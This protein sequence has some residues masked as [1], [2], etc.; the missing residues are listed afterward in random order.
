MTETNQVRGRGRLAGALLVLALVV[1]P[2]FAAAADVLETRARSAFLIDHSSRTVLYAKAPDEA[3][4]PGSLAKVMTAAVVFDALKSG[5][6]F[7]ETL[8]KVSE[9][10]WRTG[11]APSRTSTMFAAVRSE[12]PVADL[13]RGLL[14]HNANDAAIVLAEG[15][16][17]SETAFAQ[18]MTALATR[19]GMI[20]SRFANPTGFEDPGNRTT[21][22]DM[23]RLAA[24]ILDTHR[25]RYELFSLPEFTWNRIFQRNKNPLLGEIRGLDGLGAGL[26]Q[27]DGYSGL[28]SVE[29]DGRRVI[30]VIAGLDTDKMRLAALRDLVEGAWEAFQVQILFGRGEP[31]ASAR[32]YGGETG[33]VPLVAKD[34]IAVLLPVGGNRDYR[35]R[36]VYSGPFVAPVVAGA[37]AGELRVLAADNSV[38]YSAPLVT[39]AE[40]ARGTL[41]RR[42]LDGVVEL[43]FGW[44]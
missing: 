20:S 35:L 19:I 42:S 34:P 37:P 14:V 26:S 15:L 18:R 22:R 36:A 25:T 6:V 13:L 12:I 11:G 32:V 23:A 33:S 1:L 2:A 39:G 8:F 31:V 10:A 7:E 27:A 38:V 40:V 3:F 21:A 43:L 41:S 30:A 9:H 5:E 29:R 16:A 4:A 24:Y 28:A 44:F 17:G